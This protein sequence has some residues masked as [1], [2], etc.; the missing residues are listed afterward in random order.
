MSRSPSAGSSGTRS[1]RVEHA[2]AVQLII[3]FRAGVSAADPAFLA[4][5][6]EHIGT[7]LAYLH[8]LS[9]GAHLLQATVS[10]TSVAEVV[11]RL[12]NQADV[13]DV[14]PNIT[15]QRQ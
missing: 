10:P 5:L 14:Q 2:A 3:V 1:E 9:G 12:K 4:A 7:P 6:A 8:P 15:V 11:H 13:V